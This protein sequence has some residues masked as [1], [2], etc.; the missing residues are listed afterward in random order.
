MKNQMCETGELT[1]PTDEQLGDL[2][3]VDV[4]PEEDAKEEAEAQ[5]GPLADEL[6]D[7]EAEE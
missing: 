6:A 2:A 7:V 5:A 1:L 4:A 3:D